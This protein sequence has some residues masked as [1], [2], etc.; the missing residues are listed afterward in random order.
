MFSQINTDS[1]DDFREDIIEKLAAFLKSL[2][3]RDDDI[4]ESPTYAFLSS[5]KGRLFNEEPLSE[6][7]REC[8]EYK[9]DGGAKYA[10]EFRECI[11]SICAIKDKYPGLMQK[12]DREHPSK[13]IKANVSNFSIFDKKTSTPLIRD[14][15]REQVAST[16]MTSVSKKEMIQ[17]LMAES[18]SENYNGI[19]LDLDEIYRSINLDQYKHLKGIKQTNAIQQEFKRKI[20]SAIDTIIE[21][22]EKQG[23]KRVQIIAKLGVHYIPL[24]IDIELQSCCIYDPSGDLRRTYFHLTAFSNKIKN[25][26]DTYSSGFTI[27]EKMI[28]SGNPQKLE[29]GCD[30]FAV[31]LSRQF[32]KLSHKELLSMSTWDEKSRLHQLQWHK[33][34]PEIMCMAQSTSIVSHYMKMNP[35]QAEK[36]MH[37][38]NNNTVNFGFQQLLIGFRKEID[39]ICITKSEEQLVAILHGS[40][41]ILAEAKK[42]TIR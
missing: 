6:I 42:P 19:F 16:G 27:N 35:R 17:L 32:S 8:H 29:Y 11:L 25:V 41:N 20:A 14:L 26:I 39:E 38:T 3:N 37:L 9:V 12:D 33:L 15:L 31:Y 40:E 2:K 7:I 28:N 23:I 13:E 24:D 21:N 18:K 5:I 10:K 36:M 4:V 22:C 30:I 1:L 34:P